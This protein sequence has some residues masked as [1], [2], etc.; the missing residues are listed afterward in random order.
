MS[1]LLVH[2]TSIRKPFSPL[3]FL[4]PRHSPSSRTISTIRKP[5]PIAI[6][7]GGPCGLTFARLL[8]TAGID[9]V[10]FERDTSPENALQFQGGTLDLH[11]DTGQEALRRAG[12]IEEFEKLARR[13]ATT[14][15][16]QDF[17]G[18]LRKRF[19]E[20]RDAPEIDRLQLR[21]LLLKSLPAHRIR[22]ASALQG[23]ERTGKIGHGHGADCTLQFADGST[24]SGFRLV[25][26]ADGAWSRVRP[27]ITPAQPQYTGRMFIEGRISPGNPQYAAAHEMVGAG[28]SL[29]MTRS[30]TLCIQQMSDRSYRV[31]MGLEVPSTFT[32]PGGEADITNPE[33]AR[34]AVLKY[35][36]D[37]APHL[38]AFAEAAEGP[39][40]PWPLHRVDPD[41]LLDGSPNWTR[42]PG[43]TLLGDAAHLATP[44]GDGVNIAMYDALV[45]FDA[46]VA[47]L[48]KKKSNAQQEHEDAEAIE[49]A[50]ATYEADMRARGRAHI[51]DSIE[52]EDM[53]FAE[54]GAARMHAMINQVEAHT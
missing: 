35:Y 45:L 54:D 47:E 39:W 20:G 26:G 27:L 25:V 4:K 31:Y 2:A 52:V 46:L 18:N 19:G 10:V 40:R 7:G 44:N 22:W 38:R 13:D 30:C 3:T 43:V 41:I 6:V 29:S 23:V 15:I 50:I 21:Q 24:E 32:K 16:V 14:V 28:N 49:R 5:A 33:K 9:Y 36:A 37:W 1:R 11:G 48:K 42:V 12:L 34:A 8:E 51:V 17:R 53:M